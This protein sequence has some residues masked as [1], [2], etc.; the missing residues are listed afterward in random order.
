[1]EKDIIIK[2]DGTVVET[3]PKNGTDY[4]LEELQGI[5]D[6][7]IECIGSPDRKRVMVLNEEGKLNALPYNHL[8]TEIFNKWGFPND[9]IVGDVLVADSDKI[10]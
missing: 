6:G 9:Y 2:T 3:E 5:V 4:S 1:M 8:A 7:Y 10:K